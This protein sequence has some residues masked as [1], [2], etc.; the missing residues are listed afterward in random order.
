MGLR[1]AASAW[2]YPSRCRMPCVHSSSSSSRSGWCAWPAWSAATSGQSTT[3]PS[4]PGGE[5]TSPPAPWSPRALPGGG[6]RSSSIGKASTSVGPGSP[7]QRS[8]SSDMVPRS[9]SRTESSASGWI[10][11]PSRTCRASDARPASSTPTPDSLAISML[12][13]GAGSLRA[14]APLGWGRP[15]HPGVVA[16]VSVHDVPHQPVPHHVLAGQPG[17]VHI[18]QALENVL[19]DP[20]PAGLAGRQVDL[21]D[22]TSHDD[23]RAEAEPG[24]EHLHLFGGGVLRLVQGDERVVHV[25][26]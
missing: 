25:P 9:T 24:E 5:I 7:I 14:L 21:G 19:D 11:T 13:A 6:G 2:S 22:V 18:V 23:L 1:S 17:E 16:V 4:R 8:C 20:Q 3:S 10:R 12:T 15:A 26:R